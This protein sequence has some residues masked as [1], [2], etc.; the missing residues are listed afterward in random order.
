MQETPAPHESRLPAPFIVGAPRSGTTL[1]RLM[2]DNHPEIA[3]PHET[4]FFYNLVRRVKGGPV[5]LVEFHQLLVNHFTWGDFGLDAAEFQR[6]LEVLEP[7]TIAEGLRTFYR[8]YAA[9]FRKRRWGEKTPDYGAIAPDIKLI[10]EEAYFIHMIRDGR[11]V[12]VSTRGLWF[13]PGD[14]IQAL[15]ERW[16][17]SV[18]CYRE[19]G[20]R[21]RHYFEIKYEDLVRFP[22]SALAQI[23]EFIRLPYSAAM[24]DYH[25]RSKERLEEIQG[26]PSEG[27]TAAQLK[28]LHVRVHLP[29]ND[30]RVERWKTELSTDEVA[31]F[32]D[33]AG[34]ALLGFGYALSSSRNRSQ[35]TSEGQRT[36]GV[37]AVLL[38]DGISDEAFEHFSLLRE[39]ADGFVI[40]VD[41]DGASPQTHKRAGELGTAVYEIATGGLPEIRQEMLEACETEWILR[42]DSDEELS[43]EWTDGTWRQLLSL[44]DYTHFFTPRRWLRSANT[45]VNESPWW[46][47][48]QLR[49]FRKRHGRIGTPPLLHAPIAMTG[50]GGF[51]R[52][53]TIEHHALWK[54]PRSE[55]EAKVR[56]YE[57]FRPE[58][59]L[60]FYYLPENYPLRESPVPANCSFDL[61]SELLSMNPLTAADSFAISLEASELPIQVSPRQLFWPTV[62]LHNRSPYSLNCGC[63]APVQLSYHW[64]NAET[65]QVVVF[66]GIRTPIFP[67]IAPGAIAIIHAAIAAPIHPGRYLLQIT[68]VQEGVLWFEE[69]NPQF[70]H[71]A[72]VWVDPS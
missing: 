39:Q 9:R 59:A 15:A 55:R 63:P 20:Q 32:E 30:E 10:L 44:S 62:H 50:R 49:L 38:T 6:C 57:Q 4:Q 72:E 25:L 47:D 3:I 60:G 53:L 31:A 69:A 5:G 14:S 41:R 64:L 68:L 66:E 22:E 8:L 13:T 45:F 24:L 54:A 33:V 23:C 42:I 35:A 48:P 12:A 51:C 71:T 36:G 34:A 46:P 17:N 56:R 28:D 37:S 2:I 58:G 43:A 61:S 52:R 18:S 19:L 1:L 16:S 11:D 65:R 27:V 26:W 7:F 29:P 67:E 70:P 40:F 21:C